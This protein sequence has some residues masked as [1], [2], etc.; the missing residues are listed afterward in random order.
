MPLTTISI[1]KPGTTEELGYNTSGEICVT[2]PGVMLGY[3]NPEATAKALMVHEDG[4]TWLHM[5]DTGY[6]DEDGYIYITGRLKSVIVLEN[7]KNVFPEEIE[8]YL[9]NIPEIGECVALGRKA[10]DGETVNLCALVYPNTEIYGETPD[11]EKAYA[12]ILAKI[13]DLNHQ[14]PTF[15]KIKVLEIVDA[16]F[17][18]T[19]TRKI[20]R[21]LVK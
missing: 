19:T 21:H 9:A 1:F 15:K 2:G 4:K 17:E 7:G 3:D 20:K 18:K 10:E 16:P 13:N 11:K 14:L 12:D 6:M 8:E 5:G